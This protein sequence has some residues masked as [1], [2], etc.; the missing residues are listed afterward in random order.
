M[1]NKNLRGEEVIQDTTSGWCTKESTDELAC[2]RRVYHTGLQ[3]Y[4]R[5]R[6]LQV[7]ATQDA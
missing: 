4:I 6:G 2:F 3:H 1:E 5:I 7:S